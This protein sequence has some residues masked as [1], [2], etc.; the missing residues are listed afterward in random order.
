MTQSPELAGGEG[1]TF[2]GYVAAFYLSALLAEAYARG[3]SG[4]IV[5]GVSVQQRDF[6]EP[7]DDVIVDFGDVDDNKARLSLQVKRSLTISS[8]KTNTD[9]KDIIRDSWATLTKSDFQLGLDR[10][11][12]AVGT[13]SAAK[14]RELNRLCELARESQATTH[15][16]ARFLEEG[17]ASKE[18]KLVKACLVELLEEVKG[19]ACTP[20][21][22]H[23]FLAHF[24]LIKF[25]FLHEG[26]TDSPEA[27]NSI[28]GALAAEESY[29]VPLV[30]SELVKLARDSAG[31]A[32]QFDRARLVRQLST[33]AR[34]R[35]ANSMRQDLGKL[36]ELAK[37]Y[38]NF[39]PD[40]VGGT[41]LSRDKLISELDE[42]CQRARIIQVTGLPG[43][44]KSVLIRRS[45]ERAMDKGSILFLKAEQLEGSSWLSFASHHGL[46]NT[47]LEALLI[48]IGASGTPVLFIDAIDRVDK[49]RQGIV[50][51]LIRTIRQSALL[52]QWHIITSLR[53]S[54]IEVLRNWLG[55]YLDDLI[56]ETVN[57]NQL[58]DDE[59]E[60][61]AQE[62]P[63]LRS[64]LFGT[65]EVQSVVRRPFF[66]KIL[67]QSY[68]AD[69]HNQSFTP[70]SEVDLIEH[71][72]ERGGYNEQG[73][74][75]LERQQ[76]LLVLAGL[77]A[78][79]LSK[80]I[81]LSQLT[82][83]QHIDR[84]KSDGVLQDARQGISMHFSH[85]IFFEWAFFYVLSDKGEQWVEEIKAC[86]EPP[87]VARIV[88]LV[89][90]WEYVRGENW[91][92]YLALT[93][94]SEI[95]S[96]WQ[97]AWLVGPLGNSGFETDE[98]QFETA[99]LA[100]E[101]N[102]LRKA[103]VWFQAEKTSPNK[104]ILNDSLPLQERQRFADLLGGPSDFSAWRRLIVFILKRISKIPQRL[105]PE[106]I[107]IFEVWQN[108]FSD[109][110]NL[111]SRAL[112]QQCANWLRDLDEIE[113]EK[114]PSKKPS[115][116]SELTNLGEFRKSLIRLLLKSSKIKSCY[117]E[118]YIQR[119][120]KARHTQDDEFDQIIRFSHV[121][122]QSIPESLVQLSL[123]YLC[124]ELPDDQ[125]AR[126]EQEQHDEIK[127]RESV[128]A[129]PS[130]DR[131]EEEQR[132]LDF[133]SPIHL[134]SG[135]SH[136]DWERLC[137]R[138]DFKSFY[139]PSPLREPFLSLFKYS[140]EHALKLL[141]SLCNHAMSAWKQLHNHSYVRGGTPLPL[142]LSFPWGVQEF[143]GSDREYLWSRGI[144]APD[145]ISSGFMAL[146]E[147]CL[148][149]IENDRPLDELIQKIVEGNESIAVLGVSS[150]LAVHS[151]T[152]TE[153]TLQL[154]S[155]PRVLMA[156]KNRWM[157]EHQSSANLMGF[158][159]KS[160]ITH[161]DAI[162]KSNSRD[163]RKT[164]LRWLVQKSIVSNEPISEHIKETILAFK[165]RLPFQ[166]EEHKKDQEIIRSL[167][168]DSAELVEL[169]DVNNYQICRV[170]G[171]S[172][173]V[174]VVHEGPSSKTP[175]NIAKIT[176]ASEYLK[177]SNLWIWASKFFEEKQLRNSFSI[178]DALI[179]AQSADSEDLFSN[180]Y[181]QCS[182][183]SL[184]MWR[185]AVAA[186]AA[187]VLNF[188]EDCSEK[189]LSW[190]RNVLSRALRLPESPD[191][192][193]STY[194]VIPWH[195]GIFVSKGLG[196]D[197]YDGTAEENATGDLISLIAHPLEIVSLA[198]IEEA[199]KLWSKNPKLTWASLLLAFSMC[200]LPMHGRRGQAQTEY[201]PQ[202]AIDIA[203]EFYNSGSGWPIFQLPPEA[204]VKINP[205]DERCVRRNYDEWDTYDVIDESEYWVEPDEFWKSQ[206]AAKILDL[207]PYEEILQSEAKDSLLDFL[208]GVLEWTNQKN[209]PHWIKSG[210]RNRAAT[211]HLLWT[212][213]LGARLGIVAGLLSLSDFQS[214]FLDP[215]LNLEGD[216]CWSILSSFSN[217]YVCAYIFD[218][219]DVPNDAVVLLDLILVRLL[220]S[221][222]FRR[223]SYRSG[224]LTGFDQP[225]LVETM[226]FVSV[227]RA[228]LAARYVNGDWSEIERIIPIIDKFIRNA[229]WAASVMYH[230]LTLCERAKDNYPAEPFADQVLSIIGDGP[231][232]LKGWN[233]TFIAAR[234][235]ELIQHFSHRDTPMNQELAQKFLKILDMLVDMGDRRSAALQL[236][237]AFREIRLS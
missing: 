98:D 68:Q 109:Y 145:A 44:G 217:T 66:A 82:S 94:D 37:S 123:K 89:S 38:V 81:K 236:S 29:K 96:Q 152:V 19:S 70:Q 190:A 147:W 208:A 186:T 22:I 120:I 11:G 56:V 5:V 1:F 205:E 28:K 57:V 33:A 177:I 234:I 84:L 36:T 143:W 150:M 8:A 26:A 197:L 16:E 62:K 97:R 3:I 78:R 55:E 169:V 218:A 132:F 195:P 166:Y 187:L 45:V 192:V 231:E 165:D 179:T 224:E 182:E 155:S 58:T 154:V 59:A 135:F 47:S 128:L 112:L 115:S 125:I 73:Q 67:N 144:W 220:K 41:K 74:N 162:K 101:S 189:D 233:G 27:I 194:S 229:G 176:E 77:R 92:S 140:P 116:W 118:E 87:A 222:V 90:Q 216:N 149:E 146:E 188:K 24:V 60:S 102:L 21:E 157:Q 131:T 213:A 136:H 12:A 48:E 214:R 198:A 207:I 40:D 130:A 202:P 86:G 196:T 181:N 107:S 7:L 17:N 39:I 230:F 63:H 237:E 167:T 172:D 106:V 64:L 110:D 69:P 139:P 210:R 184:G 104:N 50:L 85:D 203:I 30:W 46:S 127:W 168:N 103:L 209:A 204:W 83:V 180:S 161:V 174:M 235:A 6:G 49:E 31:K 65:A 23:K 119:Y 159:N 219:R 148:S 212:H 122:A 164:D 9:F 95:R 76:L 178:K 13:I 93:I 124:Q 141:K 199:C 88:E 126:E 100:D 43:S 170:E 138:D 129:K 221:S 153:V 175:E 151:Q 25:D 51:D 15:F 183:E 232:K 160:D 137:I 225:R 117:S 32:G 191:S 163:I 206:S 42:R 226:L 158:R 54:G 79:Q 14:Q 34:L 211:D 223:D 228:D 113:Y 4:R 35:G 2:E 200:K 53:D 71:W 111:V 114:M 91:T 80:P 99:V 20:D 121:L 227:E 171:E 108:V 52:D 75:A 10:Y 61:L 142:K 105:Y 72:W 18:L 156:D 173:K 185:G 201:N 215:I 193:W 134:S 133:S